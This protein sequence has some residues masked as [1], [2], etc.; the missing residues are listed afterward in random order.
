M[1]FRTRSNVARSTQND[2]VPKILTMPL[3][4]FRLAMAIGTITAFA[5]SGRVGQKRREVLSGRILKP[6]LHI[7][8]VAVAAWGSNRRQRGNKSGNGRSG[9]SNHRANHQLASITSSHSLWSGRRR[10]PHADSVLWGDRARR[11]LHFAVSSGD[12]GV[13]FPW[14]AA[15]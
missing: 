7:Y 1:I 9:G 14:V 2:A 3:S 5:C 12:P 8:E 15:Q 11:P 10:C 4:K 13:S 6:K